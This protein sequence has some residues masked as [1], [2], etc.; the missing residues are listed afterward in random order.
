[1]LMASEA[2]RAG[3]LSEGQLAEMLGLDRVRLRE[4]LD[5]LDSGEID[6]AISLDP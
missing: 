2:H 5:K 1:M 4:E 6:D 3:L